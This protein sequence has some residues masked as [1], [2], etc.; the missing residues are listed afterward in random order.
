MD[1]VKVSVLVLTYKQAKYISKCLDSILSQKVDFRYEIVVGEDCSNDGTKEM[2][3]EYQKLYPDRF[4]LLLNETNMGPSLNTHNGLVHCRGKYITACEGDD[5]WI[6]DTKMQKQVEFLETHPEYSAIATNTVNVDNEG[7]NPK[8]T[9]MKWQVNKT[10]TLKHFLRYGMVIHGNSI[11]RRNNFLELDERYCKFRYAEPTMGDVFSRVMIYDMGK[12]YVL[13]DITHAHRDG[14]LDKT[15][16][17]ATNKENTIELTKMYFRIVDN[18]TAYYGGKYNLE[19]L[20]ANRMGLVLR[21]RLIR[22]NSMLWSEYLGLWK[23][24]PYRLRWLCFERCIQ[25]L[26]REVVRVMGRKLKLYYK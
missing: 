2:L 5:F 20:K 23:E 9:L 18:I 8:V 6:D 15:S 4:V 19:K 16:Y 22:R 17:T 24:L 26:T 10:Y 25:K 12:M 11:M 14:S 7:N 3:L 21:G 13:P 1:E